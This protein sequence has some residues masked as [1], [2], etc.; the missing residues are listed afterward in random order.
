MADAILWLWVAPLGLGSTPHFTLHRLA[1]N[2]Q[3]E[4]FRFLLHVAKCKIKVK[5]YL[6]VMTYFAEL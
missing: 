4:L 3:D 5:F 6:K 2:P 1:A